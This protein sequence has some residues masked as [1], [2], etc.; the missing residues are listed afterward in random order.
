MQSQMD[1]VR[2]MSGGQIDAKVRLI[3]TRQM[4]FITNMTA[5]AIEHYPGAYWWPEKWSRLVLGIN[6]GPQ[7]YLKIWVDGVCIYTNNFDTDS[8]LIDELLIGMPYGWD[9]TRFTGSI[10]L[11]DVAIGTTFAEVGTE[12]ARTVTVKSNIQRLVNPDCFGGQLGNYNWG[13]T[14]DYPKVNALVKQVGFATG[15][16][17]LQPYINWDH[18]WPN[19][20]YKREPADPPGASMPEQLFAMAGQ[21]DPLMVCVLNMFGEKG[22]DW[23]PEESAGLVQFNEL[24]P[25]PSGQTG[26]RT[27]YELGNE[28][29]LYKAATEG[30][31]YR[32]ATNGY[33]QIGNGNNTYLKQLNPADWQY[34]GNYYPVYN[35]RLDFAPG[36]YLYIG[37]R[38]RF[39]ALAYVLANGAKVSGDKALGWEY[40][41]GAQWVR[42]GDVP[43]CPFTN[44]YPASA[45]NMISSGDWNFMEWDDTALEN[46]TRASIADISGDNS[47]SNQALYWIRIAHQSGG[48]TGESP[49][50]SYV[51]IAVSPSGYLEA[52]QAFYPVI[53]DA[54]AELYV[55]SGN[56]GFAKDFLEVTEQNPALFDGIAWHSY[57]G[58]TI[59]TTMVP[60]QTYA[61]ATSMLWT[62]DI[63]TDRFN[64]LRQR[65][66]NKRIALTEWNATGTPTDP[67]RTLA[68]GLRTAIGLC[69]ILRSGWD[70]A[71]YHQP[72][73]P[74]YD[75]FCLI[76]GPPDKPRLR[77]SGWAFQAVHDHS[78]Q[79]VLETTSTYGGICAYGFGGASPQ[80]GSL[81][82]VNRTEKAESV[83]ISLPRTWK[84]LVAVY[85]MT[86]ASLNADNETADKVTLK[87]KTTIQVS[88]SMVLTYKVPAYSLT[89]FDTKY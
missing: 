68:G 86:A 28:V 60:G 39:H 61:P 74:Y 18:H 35:Y 33:V 70:S 64:D 20:M 81:I 45:H 19:L 82:L 49:V 7:G 30:W 8:R 10:L 15:R 76:V 36:D 43:Y 53:A 56:D 48:Y 72:Y 79:Y 6:K 83:K 27:I 26:L 40:W 75:P 25:R 50:E 67:I 73:Y 77:P 3:D 22:S 34:L 54:G 52:M 46:W 23:R 58:L 80:E 87:R 78:K 4:T 84:R 29:C 62:V 65:F 66:P 69:Q 59:S 42:F 5:S 1:L 57:P 38:W 55:E 63:L 17:F 41:N 13:W 71:I 2:L 89:V 51:S 21:T 32:P 47:L 24:Y 11:D 9:G 44:E 85:E 88:S 12:P 31:Y 14:T 16:A 37:E